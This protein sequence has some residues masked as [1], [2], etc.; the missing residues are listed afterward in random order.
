M[1]GARARTT[2]A[3]RIARALAASTFA[4]ATAYRA[5]IVI[6]MLAGSLPLIM[7][8][9]WMELAAA[10]PMGGY[11]PRAFAAYF[12][13]VFLVRQMTPAWVMG[14]LD[15]E[16]RLGEMSPLLLRPID[17]YW[18]HAAWHLVGMVMKLPF[19]VPMVVAGLALADALTL[20]HWER[21]PLFLLATLGGWAIQ[22]NLMYALGLIAFWTDQATAL[23][24][25][26][27]TLLQVLGGVLIPLDLYPEAMRAL[28][29]YTP[30]YYVVS[31]PVKV[32]TGDW[33]AA[34]LAGTFAVQA[35][36]IAGIVAVQRLLWRRG[37]RRYGAVGA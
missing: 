13:L 5:E 14:S 29:P 34:A 17:P 27:F 20:P 3:L 10:G 6:W 21:L 22:F 9:V 1:S 16:I 7:M 36:W 35:V 11:T 25:L 23:E 15:R 37:L 12:L 18:Q 2:R 4:E 32:L 31:F 24:S 28:L 8:F 19:V 26:A 33:S 30:Y